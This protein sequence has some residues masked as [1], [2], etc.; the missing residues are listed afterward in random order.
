MSMKRSLLA[1]PIVLLAL[2]CGGKTETVAKPVARPAGAATPSAAQLAKGKEI[3]ASRCS[4]CHGETADG[5]TPISAGYPGANLA[6]GKWVH[7]GTPD[8]I[9][10]TI[11]NGVPDTPMQG[12]REMMMASDIDAVTAYVR[13][14]QPAKP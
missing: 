4:F 1:A 11:A 2:A 13:S 6:D 9:A 7:G 10:L 12:F 5:D 3:Y 8:E 14:L